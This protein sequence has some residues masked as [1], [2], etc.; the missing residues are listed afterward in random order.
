VVRLAGLP[1]SVLAGLRF[2]RTSSLVVELAVGQEWLAR[3]GGALADALHGVIG[4]LVDHPA[5]PGL[6]GLRRALHQG[7][8]PRT[9]EWRP[10]TEALLPAPLA[11]RVR[12]WLDRRIAWHRRRS[13]LDRVVAAEHA[14]R[15]RALRELAADPVFRRGLWHSSRT[16]SDEL[17]RWLADPD[18]TPRRQV[19]LRLAK[20]LARA[21]A[22]SAVFSS[23][24]ATGLGRW[25]GDG[26]QPGPA[27]PALRPNPDPDLRTVT[28]C[29]DLLRERLLS[30]MVQ[31]PA[32]GRVLAVRINPSHTT[33]PDG[34]GHW[35]LGPPPEEPVR[36]LRPHPVL[37]QCLE[38]AGRAGAAAWTTMGV[39]TEQ[40]S[41]ATGADPAYLRGYLHRLSDAGLLELGP[42][43]PARPAVSLAGLA[44][45]AATGEDPE[46]A[47]GL[48]RL[49]EALRAT[50]Q[51]WELAGHRR[52]HHAIT[53]AA[54]GIAG[55]LGISVDK[56]RAANDDLVAA[57]PLA[58][59]RAP[60]W[61]P[62]LADLSALRCW[63]GL[64]DP[65]LPLRMALRRW[66]DDHQPAHSTAPLLVLYQRFRATA[67]ALD[68]LF[69]RPTFPADLLVSPVPGL[70]QVGELQSAALAALPIQ[71]GH[72]EPIRIPVADLVATA[73]TW[74]AWVRPIDEMTCYMQ[75]DGRQAVLNRLSAGYG[76]ASH[77]TAYLRRR[78][79]A[80]PAVPVR[81]RGPDVLAELGG[82][83]GTALNV[84]EPCLPYEID[85]PFAPSTRPA[86]QRI[87][88][89]ELLV[90]RDRDGEL[91]VRSTRLGAEVRPVYNGALI[92]AQ[93]PPLARLLVAG[94]GSP[95]PPYAVPMPYSGL[96]T[97]VRRV[98]RISFGSVVV[99]RARWA[100]PPALVPIRAT[101][102]TDADYLLRLAGWRRAHGIPD[103]CFVRALPSG[104]QTLPRGDALQRTYGN[105]RK[106]TY[107]D[108]TSWFL[109]LAFENLLRTPRELVIFEEALPDPAASPRV[110]ELLVEVPDQEVGNP[111]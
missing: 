74:P 2:P 9:R 105:L 13:E 100:F 84:R 101:G 33:S 103:R 85:Y 26:P 18:R 54:R 69:T 14:A 23:F 83:Y 98:P 24:A 40:L 89:A 43:L 110:A 48:N 50:E 79:G 60:H 31:E 102:G 73:A 16:L 21:S 12:T 49:E 104:D 42:P 28:A 72:S 77:R 25:V 90:T 56:P 62:A 22:K 76:T 10:E 30:A 94:F 81:E 35:F 27:G 37:Q 52:S 7:R 93:L 17:D 108:F 71:P 78:A 80:D 82:L 107:V 99:R 55:R 66:W 68:G 109:V 41:E 75:H 4:A 70:A 11:T 38:L 45:W 6:V 95:T 65:A 5:K 57:G 64:F 46:L 87:P 63:L 34:T 36:V 39:L 92:P 47:A 58:D 19:Q 111:R 97:G 8:A 61:R 91:R 15:V 59:C 51:Q 20:Y 32:L 44:G 3:E 106:P 67:A 88:L 86:D 96:P 53:T 1:T 29:D